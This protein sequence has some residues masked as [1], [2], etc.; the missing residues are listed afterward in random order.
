MS[1]ER[2]ASSGAALPPPLTLVPPVELSALPEP[3]IPVANQKVVAP[4]ELRDRQTQ[5]RRSNSVSGAD[6][7]VA[8]AG[9]TVTLV[10]GPVSLPTPAGIRRIDV[11]SAEQM[12][13]VVM[14]NI[15]DADIFIGVAA[16]SDY[17]PANSAAA[18][19]AG[20]WRTI[21]TR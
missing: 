15:A 9:A 10:S 14:E 11:V 13:A 21:Q 7:A 1:E 6:E 18:C 19:W 5:R 17:R 16:V 3:E 4:P 20:R 2:R 12:A 8:R